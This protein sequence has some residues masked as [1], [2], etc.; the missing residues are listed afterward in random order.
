MIGPDSIEK[1]TENKID[2][3]QII[4]GLFDK[5]LFSESLEFNNAFDFDSLQSFT[6][7]KSGSF[8]RET[9]KNALI[10]QCE[11]DTTYIIKLYKFKD[12]G[13]QIIDS[14]NGLEAF[15]WQYDAI[16]DDYNFDG[17]KDIFIQLSA[18]NGWSLSRGYLFILD[19]STMRLNLHSETNDFANMSPDH[20]TQT[21]LSQ[22]WNG[23][24]QQG[25]H[26]ITILK[27]KWIDGQ[28]LT[29]SKKDTILN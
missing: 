22:E 19:Q 3:H 1:Q 9:E 8:L 16:F 18:S 13:W 24:N 27:N 6:F 10:V 2:S 15:P 26:Q 5:A 4:S 12:N 29:V 23:Y 21:I 20:Q 14:I 7:F 17:Q 25:Q 28:L 11:K